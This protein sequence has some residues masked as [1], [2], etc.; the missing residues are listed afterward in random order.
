MKLKQLMPLMSDY[1]LI[2]IEQDVCV[3]QGKKNSYPTELDEKEVQGISSTI[4][5]G[6]C[7]VVIF[8]RTEKLFAV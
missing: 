7:A 3:F 8:L 2:D 5:D 1:S 6:D 4:V